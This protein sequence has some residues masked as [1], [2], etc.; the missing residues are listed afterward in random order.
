LFYCIPTSVGGGGGSNP[1]TPTLLIGKLSQQWGG[2]FV[3]DMAHFYI[4]YSED[5]DRF[6]VGYTAVTMAER[7]NAHLSNHNGFTGKTKDW[8]VAYKET[9]ETK[10]EAYARE[11]EVKKWKSRKKIVELIDSSGV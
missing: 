10:S 5:L 2:F 4:L 8:I 7:L 6:Y 1:S 3:F 11:R 9:F